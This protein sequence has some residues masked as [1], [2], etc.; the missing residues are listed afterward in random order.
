MTGTPWLAVL[1]RIRTQA[2]DNTTRV[3]ASM[4]WDILNEARDRNVDLIVDNYA[5]KLLGTLT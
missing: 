2:D 4:L 3:L 5:R 1:D